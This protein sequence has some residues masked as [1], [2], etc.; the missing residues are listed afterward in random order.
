MF[1]VGLKLSSG[2]LL[3]VQMAKKKKGGAKQASGPPT[4]TATSTVASRQ[5]TDA[6]ATADVIAIANSANSNNIN[7][8][9]SSSSSSSFTEEL[10]SFDAFEDETTDATV[11]NANTNAPNSTTNIINGFGAN[12]FYLNTNGNLSTSA[13]SSPLS[14][15]STLALAPNSLLADL[16]DAAGNIHENTLTNPNVNAE[17]STDASD[18]DNDNFGVELA[19]G[20]RLPPAVPSSARVFARVASLQTQQQQQSQLQ[21][22]PQSLD[23]SS[24]DIFADLSSLPQIPLKHQQSS[25]VAHD[26]Q[27]VFDT[28]TASNKAISIVSPNSVSLSIIHDTGSLNLTVG[29]L[30]SKLDRLEKIQSMFNELENSYK[31]VSRHN[32]RVNEILGLHTHLTDG[33]KVGDEAGLQ[34]L[35]D[36][37]KS[38]SIR[39]SDLEN[40]NQR[41]KEEVAL[42]KEQERLTRVD[43]KGKDQE[44]EKL[45]DSIR[46][47][48]DQITIVKTSAASRNTSPT[49][50]NSSIDIRPA[51][52]SSNNINGS[53]TNVSKISPSTSTP[54]LATAAA[55]FNFRSKSAI[56]NPSAI[57]PP[58]LQTIEP[59]ITTQNP[60]L[61]DA[62]NS[63][64]LKLKIRELA[65]ALK[66]VTSQRDL[67]ITRIKEMQEQLPE[68]ENNSVD[69]ISNERRDSVDELVVGV[70]SY[71]KQNTLVPVDLDAGR[72]SGESL[73]GL[74]QDFSSDGNDSAS[75]FSNSQNQSSH[76]RIKALE[77]EISSLEIQITDLTETNK[78]L[79]SGNTAI[80]RKRNSIGLFSSSSP[81]S[82]SLSQDALFRNVND[83]EVNGLE[84]TILEKNEVIKTMA[85]RIENLEYEKGTLIETVSDLETQL[86]DANNAC[87]DIQKRLDTIEDRHAR[88]LDALAAVNDVTVKT[89]ESEL[90]SR[91]RLLA[92]ERER[93]FAVR[94]EIETLRT[95]KMTV[96]IQL[97][98]R[99][100][101]LRF[102]EATNRETM[103]ALTASEVSKKTFAEAAEARTRDLEDQL[104]D[105]IDDLYQAAATRDTAFE[106]VNIKEGVIAELR[107][108]VE[109]SMTA[110]KEATTKTEK[111]FAVIK[112][113]KNDAE[114]KTRDTELVRKQ[115]ENDLSLARNALQLVE[116][117]LET[118]R[119]DFESLK[120]GNVANIVVNSNSAVI[121][122]DE[123]KKLTF[124]IQELSAVNESLKLTQYTH[125]N[126]ETLQQRIQSLESDIE[127][128]GNE[129]KELET[130]VAARIDKATEINKVL[131]NNLD[132]ILKDLDQMAT[133]VVGFAKTQTHSEI[134]KIVENRGR[135]QD[136][137]FLLDKKDETVSTKT[138]KALTIVKILKN[139]FE[140]KVQE[141]VK[142]RNELDSIQTEAQHAQ[143]ELKKVLKELENNRTSAVEASA[144]EKSLDSGE[145]ATFGTVEIEFNSKNSMDSDTV[146]QVSKLTQQMQELSN[147]NDFLKAGHEDIKLLGSRV[148]DLEAEVATLE[149]EK[150]DFEA[151]VLDLNE[152]LKVAESLRFET[153]QSLTLSEARATIFEKQ[154]T[155]TSNS[156]EATTAARDEAFEKLRFEQ[157]V[158]SDLREKADTA[159]IEAEKAFATIEK[160]TAEID[161]KSRESDKTQLQLE[162]DL[163]ST[164]LAINH[165]R[166]ELENLRIELKVHQ[167]KSEVEAAE[168]AAAAT[169]DLSNQINDLQLQIQ[170]LSDLNK[171]LTTTQYKHDDVEKLIERIKELENLQAVSNE[172]PLSQSKM[173]GECPHENVDLLNETIANLRAQ[174]E[175]VVPREMTLSRELDQINEL[176]LQVQNLSRQNESLKS[177]Q[178]NHT[179]VEELQAVIANFRMQLET[180]FSK[181]AA[182]NRELE[183]TKLDF[184]DAKTKLNALQS[185]KQE[186][187]LQ[188]DAAQNAQ[189]EAVAK[190]E[191]A[192]A[193]VRKMKHDSET[194]QKETEAMKI[195]H[196]AE[197]EAVNATLRIAETERNL[198]KTE[199]L[200]SRDAESSLRSKIDELVE[201][202]ENLSGFVESLK[203]QIKTLEERKVDEQNG[204]AFV[205]EE[206]GNEVTAS[207]IENL[208]TD[209]KIAK[210]IARANAAEEALALE[211]Q[212]I[213]AYVESISSKEAELVATK[214]KLAEEEEKK[215]KSI[216]LLR[217]MKAKILKLE[218]IVQSRDAEL[219]G[220][221]TELKELRTNASTGAAERDAKLIALTKQVEEMGARIRKQNDDLFQL[222]KQH[223]K[224]SSEVDELTQKLKDMKTRFDRAVSEREAMQNA[225]D[226]KTDE[227]AAS[228]STFALQ[229]AQLV[230]ADDRLKDLEFRISTL[231]EELE[232][233]K[234]L[235]ENKSIEYETLKI[236]TTELEQQHYEKEQFVGNNSEEV[237]Q[238]T[239]EI[240]Q[241]RKDV[242][243]QAKVIR[244]RDTD[245]FNLKQEK[246]L[247]ETRLA[248]TE[249]EYETLKFDFSKIR[250][251]VEEYVTAE[252]GWKAAALQIELLQSSK[253]LEINS[254]TSELRA[255]LEEQQKLVD[256]AKGREN[257]LLKLNKSLKDEVRKLARSMGIATPSVVSPP[258]SHNNS[259]IDANDVAAANSSG[260]SASRKSSISSQLD[261]TGSSSGLNWVGS[262]GKV[263]P[264]FPPYN[265]PSRNN[266][267]SSQSAP[268]A[269]IGGGQKLAANEEY[270]KNVV[271]RFVESKRDTK[272]QMV[273]ALGMLLRLSP[274]E[275][276]RVQKAI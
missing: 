21:S 233:S 127:A 113:L 251:K 237:E 214:A 5:S 152:K 105:A 264:I 15:S 87:N 18:N 191:K 97:E 115:L 107:E 136:L 217:N 165:S 78:K 30:M 66:K 236:Q 104:K 238:Y 154:L 101:Q 92:S 103:E 174:L 42:V 225:A 59:S 228:R 210:L 45:H 54:T 224:K 215:T 65:N 135:S 102:V 249:K 192:F 19:A 79:R 227:L 96:Q 193:V 68:F 201:Q 57:T 1:G 88:D 198:L 8:S 160:L 220:L 150:L 82:S 70:S 179:N 90:D 2:S 16:L 123:V 256:D 255:K 77:A 56:V 275:L 95:E 155:V 119:K 200:S 242:A 250:S 234:R 140:M 232:T 106:D 60:S 252:E 274:D 132:K 197:L 187:E 93:L 128:M 108:K 85:N 91:A 133:A 212:S 114:V 244:E 63:L 6:D 247:M 260:P 126:F 110:Q 27:T 72:F 148:K 52:S 47:L 7:N 205:H 94:E 173:V 74:L 248:R 166:V 175:S 9:A 268:V 13:V 58:S 28:N 118:T 81:S 111:A 157:I 55:F 32:T 38:Q 24:L 141:I 156:L 183:K 51:K 245:A 206:S 169:A 145:F 230:A 26:L 219:I 271:L 143:V 246:N 208:E 211:K 134:D 167:S 98:Q 10:F 185:L 188:L 40:S 147:L 163:A 159:V 162:T 146:S 243:S 178:C 262:I 122:S 265:P 164:K 41:L 172:D 151:Q 203:I 89:L 64:Q 231:D 138:E 229:A 48:E 161:E 71:Q 23:S 53:V 46:D 34:K 120:A 131:E 121:L 223:G 142:T 181:E 168:S 273:P 84:S 99:D 86:R 144:T 20:L 12:A 276:K 253:E 170:D 218:D 209:A 239:R 222:E 125:T 189:Q 29:E 43:N 100:E 186:F 75:P 67:A 259:G 194:R 195:K 137:S 269:S 202:N 207:S 25:E 171:S 130:H 36:F 39:V 4:P 213:H 44:I 117:E 124:E 241:L 190:T 112:K 80:T 261:F 50:G 266:S 129:K 76:Q 49:R 37:L 216:Q 270:L 258:L 272:L 139:E 83:A 221:Q 153:T 184:V 17:P 158:S 226:E 176:V 149:K 109:F 69:L 33:I 235:F 3:T 177:N 180:A 35:N 196:E 182:L 62:A 267:Q 254:R 199:T 14:L 11:T 204:A 240:L 31:K 263:A 73:S 22:Q 61:Q 116:A 257:Q